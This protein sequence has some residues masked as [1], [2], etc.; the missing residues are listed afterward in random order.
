M[1]AEVLREEEDTGFVILRVM[2]CLEKG[3]PERML[4]KGDGESVRAE[5][6]REP[7]EKRLR[8]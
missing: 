7:R 8:D 4:W 1:T 5:F 6:V 3:R 2:A